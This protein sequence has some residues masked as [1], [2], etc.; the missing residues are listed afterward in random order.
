MSTRLRNLS[1]VGP[2][3]STP[4]ELLLLCTNT[5]HIVAD[6]AQEAVGIPLLHLADATAYAV[7]RAGLQR[8]G[9]LGTAFTMEQ[10]FYRGR[11]ASHGIEVLIPQPSDRALVHRVI[12]DELQ[13][14]IQGGG[15][16]QARRRIAPGMPPG[17]PPAGPI[18]RGQRSSAG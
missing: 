10:P 4:A 6:H 9:L 17:H 18:S 12:Y 7:S 3:V 13:G 1:T 5:M 11:L 15:D 14:G 16:M 2:N 8:V